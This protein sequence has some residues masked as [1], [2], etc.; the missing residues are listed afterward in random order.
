MDESTTEVVTQEQAP[1]TAQ[2]DE[3]HAEAETTPTSEPTTPTDPTTEPVDEP[4]PADNSDSDFDYEAWLEKKGIDPASPEGKAAIAKSW[5]E[6]EKKMHQTTQQSSELEKQ[7]TSQPP[8]VSDDPMVQSLANEVFNMR[9]QNEAKEF[10]RENNVSDEQRLEFVK[11]LQDNPVKQQLVDNGYMSVSEA[12]ALSG[13][14]KQDTNAIE[15][16]G[17]RK[18]LETLANQQRT[19]A[20][21]GSATTQA[22]AASDPI[23]EE[24]LKD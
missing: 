12:Y 15:Q 21:K 22:P 4:A 14:G 19:T 10:I 17:G 5:R 2:P 13:V 3:Q 1:V 11:Y 24:L 16:T 18:A 7:L 8:Q 23:L 6:M 20:P 9:M